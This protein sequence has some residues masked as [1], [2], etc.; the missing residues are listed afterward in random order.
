M[1]AGRS[2]DLRTPQERAEQFMERVTAE[3]SRRLTR[4]A[5]RAREEVED[6]VAEARSLNERQQSAR[7]RSRPKASK[8]PSSSGA[9]DKR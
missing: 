9:N 5:G 8:T 2:S 3:A 1:S 4:F 7:S 6:I